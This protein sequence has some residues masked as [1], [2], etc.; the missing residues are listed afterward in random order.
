M[1]DRY[2]YN[3][4]PEVRPV[5]AFELSPTLQHS[6]WSPCH[7]WQMVKLTRSKRTSEFKVLNGSKGRSFDPWC[8]SGSVQ[9]IAPLVQ[10]LLL[11]V[12]PSPFSFR[13]MIFI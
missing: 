4:G 12:H 2:V 6:V 13:V 10:L 3:Y 7:S 11:S 9:M 5:K 1:G 8:Q